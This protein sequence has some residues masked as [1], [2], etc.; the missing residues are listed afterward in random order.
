MAEIQD[1]L[2]PLVSTVE[3]QGRTLRSL[4]ANGSG[5]PPGYLEMAR[6]EDKEAQSRISRK[7]DKVAERMEFVE[8]FI[9]KHNAREDQ[10]DQDRKVEAANVA[11]KLEQ[12]EKRS[13]KRIAL[14]GL[15]LAM[16]MAM[17]AVY[18]HRDGIRR[19]LLE[20][21]IGA[22]SENMPQNAHIPPLAR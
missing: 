21:Q 8:D 12:A 4:Y 1:R 17:F 13:N 15:I 7:L 6:A 22:H 19:S 11:E 18:D 5:G 10:R 16:L 9:T 20:P 2:G 3:A 14:L